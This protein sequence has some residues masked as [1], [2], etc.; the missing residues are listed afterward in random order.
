MVH[1][2]ASVDILLATYAGNVSDVRANLPQIM[3]ECKKSLRD[4]RWRVTLAYNGKPPSSWNELKEIAALWTNVRITHVNTPGKGSAILNG[5][6]ENDADYV[7]YMDADLATEVGGVSSLIHELKKGSDLVSGSRYHPQSKIVRDPIRLLV[8]KVY[9]GVVLR[10]FLGATFSD[11][12]CGFKGFNRA[13]I[14]PILGDVRDSWFFFETELMFSAQ[15]HGLKISE[16]PVIWYERGNSSVKLIPTMINF[17]QNIWRVRT[18]P[19]TLG[20]KNPVWHQLVEVIRNASFS[21]A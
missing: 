4:V 13:R 6:W 5:L 7:V 17:F 15:I 12:Q 14:L 1:P 2:Q 16:V 10:F 9:T 18:H 21:G 11:P 20:N 3:G 8:S 19:P